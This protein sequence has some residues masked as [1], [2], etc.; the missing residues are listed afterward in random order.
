MFTA[1]DFSIHS[2][3]QRYLFG[4]SLQENFTHVQSSTT[5]QLESARRTTAPENYLTHLN[6]LGCRDNFPPKL[7]YKVAVHTVIKPPLLQSLGV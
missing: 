4:A 2:L 6:E 3:M 1:Y 5:A 7:P